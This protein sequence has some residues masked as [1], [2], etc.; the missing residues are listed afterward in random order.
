MQ[1]YT[2]KQLFNISTGTLD[3]QRTIQRTINNDDSAINKHE[4]THPGHTINADNFEVS[5]W[6]NEST[7]DIVMKIMNRRESST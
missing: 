6:R 1:L 3:L 5:K 4:K 2:C 7:R